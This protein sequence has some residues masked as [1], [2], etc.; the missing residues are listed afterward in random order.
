[1][2]HYH[3]DGEEYCEDC[4]P[5][6]PDNPV[7]DLDTGEQD[8]PAHCFHCLCPLDYSL[9]T[10]G[11][12]YVLGE[13]R[14]SLEHGPDST[15]YECY[16]GTWYDGSPHHAILRDWA[17]H[18]RHYGG[19]SEGDRELIGKYLEVTQCGEHRS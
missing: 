13:I 3:Y 11:V 14:G 15:V 7:V 19:L 17:E 8:S 6:S 2:G 18:I 10:D 9:T 1:M 16:K 5:V 4:L 12:A